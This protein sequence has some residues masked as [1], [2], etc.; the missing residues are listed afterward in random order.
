[1]QNFLSH[2]VRWI[3]KTAPALTDGDM[4]LACLIQT[5]H[6][7]TWAYHW[8]PEE[9]SALLS[10]YVTSS[11]VTSWRRQAGEVEGFGRHWIVQVC[12][13]LEERLVIL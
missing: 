12:N 7:H 9:V 4:K 8:R 13:V 11:P 5:Y 3:A 1:M 2:C 6:R 10:C